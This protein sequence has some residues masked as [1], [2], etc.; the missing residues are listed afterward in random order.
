[1][2]DRWIHE[3]CGNPRLDGEPSRGELV[4]A[5]EEALGRPVGATWW[6]EAF[7]AARYCA[8][9]VR[10][11]N[12]LEERGVMPRGTDTYLAG[13]VSDCLRLLLDEGSYP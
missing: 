13:G 3:S 12:R 5:Y 10:V 7:A 9:V 8:I 11:I 2:F 1:M 6:H 4:S